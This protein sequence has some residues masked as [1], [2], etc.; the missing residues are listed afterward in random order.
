MTVVASGFGV[1]GLTVAIAA[2]AVC[3]LIRMLG[4][5]FRIDAPHPPG[6]SGQS[7]PPEQT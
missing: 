4:L 7:E 6:T 1:H 3:F 2:A 5:R